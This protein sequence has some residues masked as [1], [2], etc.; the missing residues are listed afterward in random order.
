MTTMNKMKYSTKPRAALLGFLKAN[1]DRCFSVK[2]IINESGID[3]GEATVYRTLA[4]FAAEEK[5][6]KYVSGGRDGALYQYAGQGE[7]ENHFHLRCMKC[8]EIFHTECHVIEDMIGHIESDH[9]F[10]VD[11]VHTTI[12]GV[13]RECE[14]TEL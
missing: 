12:Y 3:V 6:K 11:A 4:A 2:D 10:R 9:G 8:G 13:C 1:A 14:G 7:C 5:V